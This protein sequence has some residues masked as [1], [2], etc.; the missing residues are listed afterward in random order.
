MAK[1]LLVTP[2]AVLFV[3]ALAGCGSSGIGGASGSSVSLD[4]E[5]QLGQQMAA[6]VAQQVHFVNDPV[7]NA[8]VRAVGERIHA[9]TPLADR[10]FDFHIVDDPEINAFSIPGG[11]V[12]VN[13]GLIGAI[14]KADELAG[15]L[16]HEESHIVARHVI[17]QAEQQQTIGAIG[18]ILL[19][20]NPGVLQQLVA[21]VLAGGAM[22]RFS[23]ADEKEADDLG[24]RFMTA[25]G[26][27]PQ[28]MVDLL[29]TLQAQE[30]T[31][32][33]K[34]ARFFADHP[35][36][37]DRIRDVQGRVGSMASS[38]GLI[39]DEPEFHEAKAR[40]AP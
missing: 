5:W 29:E 38:S 11:H 2:I 15:V 28:G 10:P 22:A 36:T 40:V 4:Q 19:G 7:A 21:Q 26:Y 1:R 24:V 18:S 35:L 31:Q 30:K 37:P 34:V 27:N 8:Y 13:R 14:D 17:K 32:P 12:Y 16:G 9:Q 6:Q 25:A 33:G 3:V 23:R 39:T 20:Q